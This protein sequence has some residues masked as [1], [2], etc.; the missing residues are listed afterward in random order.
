MWKIWGGGGTKTHMR[1]HVLSWTAHVPSRSSCL[2]MNG[3]QFYLLWKETHWRCTCTSTCTGQ[4]HE[5]LLLSA[6]VPRP[7]SAQV[8]IL[9][10]KQHG[11]WLCIFL[12]GCH[13]KRPGGEQWL[14]SS[15]FKSLCACLLLR[16][17]F[18]L[19]S[20]NLVY[21]LSQEAFLN[22]V[23]VCLQIYAHLTV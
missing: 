12:Y 15:L 22:V 14:S 5:M 9:S 21:T 20:A 16:V 19:R 1:C 23:L 6:F 17:T 2:T 3:E 18:S 13:W 10:P 11:W 7:F 4:N 8:Q